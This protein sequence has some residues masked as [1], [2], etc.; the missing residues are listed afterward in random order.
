M[1][2]VCGEMSKF[3]FRK[4]PKN[5]FV[6][7][8]EYLFATK[9][10]VQSEYKAFKRQAVSEKTTV[11][12]K[13]PIPFGIIYDHCKVKVILIYDL[14]GIS[15]KLSWIESECGNCHLKIQTGPNVSFFCRNP[16]YI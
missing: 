14:R 9:M 5:L 7:H 12:G 3:I 1:Y 4:N 8:T 11:T 15:I 16:R 6:E 13:T 2:L 10:L